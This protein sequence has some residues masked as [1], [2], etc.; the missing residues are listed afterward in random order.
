MSTLA[1]SINLHSAGGGDQFGRW[2]ASVAFGITWMLALWLALYD[3]R[4]L[5]T[6]IWT[7]DAA[8]YLG[9][10]ATGHL[11]CGGLFYRRAVPELSGYAHPNRGLGGGAAAAGRSRPPDAAVGNANDVG[12]GLM[13]SLCRLV[14]QP[15]HSGASARRCFGPALFRRPA[16]FRAAGR[17]RSRRRSSSRWKTLAICWTA[18]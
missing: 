17:A 3:L 2:L 12:P 4:A 1:R 5:L 13:R 15:M 10:S 11:D 9:L 7:P 16:R 14:I 6:G 8:L 18:D